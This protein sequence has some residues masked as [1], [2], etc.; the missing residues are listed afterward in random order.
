MLGG[1][2]APLPEE[3]EEE[4]LTAGVCSGKMA[5]SGDVLGR[6]GGG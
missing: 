6:Q 3:H 5:L 1:A 2:S 4:N